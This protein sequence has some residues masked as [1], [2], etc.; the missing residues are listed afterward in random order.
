MI[1]PEGVF[2]IT[3]VSTPLSDQYAVHV[4]WACSFAGKPAPVFPSAAPPSLPA[5]HASSLC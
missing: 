4:A 2:A 3:E 5:S 1:V